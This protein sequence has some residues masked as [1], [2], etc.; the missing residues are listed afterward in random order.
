M[1]K[2]NTI[3]EFFKR[4]NTQSSNVNVGDALSPT[5]DI[6]VSKNSSKKSRRVDVNEFE[7]DEI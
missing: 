3:L 4:Q 2:P 5:F 7:R 6:I 1:G